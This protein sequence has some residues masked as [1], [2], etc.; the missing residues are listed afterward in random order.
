VHLNLAGHALVTLADPRQP[1]SAGDR[2]SLELADPLYFD[3]SGRRL[4]TG[5]H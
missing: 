1:L 3:E 5:G 4:H 2:V